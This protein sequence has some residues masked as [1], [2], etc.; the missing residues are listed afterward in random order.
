MVAGDHRVELAFGGAAKHRVGRDRVADVDA[1]RLRR[2]RHP[3]GRLRNGRGD[4]GVRPLVAPRDDHFVAR[5]ERRLELDAFE[6]KAP[7]RPTGS[8]LTLTKGGAGVLML[9]LKVGTRP[10]RPPRRLWRRPAHPCVARRR[11]GPQQPD[12]RL[13]GPL[14]VARRQ[15]QGAPGAAAGRRGGRP[16]SPLVDPG[17]PH[18]DPGDLADTELA[19]PQ[20]GTAR[21]RGSR[22]A[23]CG[24]R[25]SVGCPPAASALGRR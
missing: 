4:R 1:A 6:Q 3:L 15:L 21:R 23:P 16:G 9:I 8:N 19:E 24:C 12:G 20:A 7:T 17:P 22:A 2:R 5:L 14:V 10:S 25:R 11:H 18:Q 13:A